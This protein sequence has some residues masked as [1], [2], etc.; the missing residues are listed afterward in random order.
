MR[1]GSALKAY[2]QSPF[3]CCRG[4]TPKRG[5]IFKPDLFRDGNGL[6]VN[7]YLPSEV[8]WKVGGTQ[9]ELVQ[10]TRYPEAET[11][12]LSLKLN[13]TAS[14]PLKFRVPQWTGDVTVKVNGAFQ[15]VAAQ[16]GSWPSWIALA[17]WRHGGSPHFRS[18]CAACRWIKCIPTGWP[19]C[20]ARWFW[21]RKLFM[22]PLPAI[23]KKQ[24]SAGEVFQPADNRPGVFFAQDDLIA[25]G[26]FRPFYT[27]GGRGA[28]PHLFRSKLRRQL[29]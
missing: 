25:R 15:P 7:L 10:E 12:S 21:R 3:T 2:D 18:N 28:L 24:R 14:F 29:W 11:I 9:V 5:R 6:C 26:A 4:P 1:W 17:E 20:T 23:P 22:T 8:N 27:F 19:S 16:P 13:G